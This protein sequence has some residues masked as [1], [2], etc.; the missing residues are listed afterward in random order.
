M[1]QI[2]LLKSPTPL[3]KI[4]EPNAPGLGTQLATGGLGT[5]YHRDGIA[6]KVFNLGTYSGLETFQPYQ[7]LNLRV[8]KCV[9]NTSFDISING[10]E[11][12]LTWAASRWLQNLI[13]D[14]IIRAEY[15]RSGAFSCVRPAGECA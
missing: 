12:N 14:A 13:R 8:E 7:P 4:G 6:Y 3:K 9:D 5:L 1:T 10:Q 2:P 11:V 15:G